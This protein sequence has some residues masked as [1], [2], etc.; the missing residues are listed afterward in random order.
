MPIRRLRGRREALTINSEQYKQKIIK[1][2]EARG[3]FV[4]ESSDTESIFPD[5]IFQHQFQHVENWLEVKATSVSL[6]DS[7]FIKQLASYLYEYL[8]R[9]V[10]N[11]FKF[12]LAAYK[13]TSDSFEKV[14]NDFNENE[15]KEL[16]KK[17]VSV[18]DEDASRILIGASFYEIRQF[19]ET[20]Q[21]IEGYPQDIDLSREKISPE[22]PEKPRFDDIK[23]ASMIMKNYDDIE[24]IDIEHSGYVNLFP[25]KLPKFISIASS[26]FSNPSDIFNTLPNVDFPPF[27]LINKMM[28]TFENYEESILRQFINIQ[29]IERIELYSWINLDEKDEYILSTILNRWIRSC[30]R[31]MGMWLDKRTYAFYFPKS[32]GSI[33]ALSKTWITPRGI[34]KSRRVTKPYK[35]DEKVNFWSHRS[36]QIKSIKKWG[37]YYLLIRPRW[38]FSEN[39]LTILEGD[40]ADK[41][42]RLFRKSLFNRNKNRLYDTLFWYDLLFKHTTIETPDKLESF[43]SLKTAP[44]I[45]VSKCLEY[46][47]Y[48]KP[49]SEMDTEEDIDDVEIDIKLDDFW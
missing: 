28:Y 43:M 42:D 21:I 32:K 23:Y 35:K 5:V 31:D 34:K 39:G 17:M 24:P 29:T 10:E 4:L 30:C 27:R 41:L 44:K 3:F 26:P 18:S 2:L 40:K 45:E 9:T 15:I 33:R 36:A 49:N 47:L 11:R 48:K 22:P 25:L 19:F 37:N 7:D 12:W 1:Y 14:F 46:K 8:I 6:G 13:L 16:I 38:L 20:S